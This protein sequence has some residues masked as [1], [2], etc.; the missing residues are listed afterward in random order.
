LFRSIHIAELSEENSGKGGAAKPFFVDTN[1]S[2]YRPM[3]SNGTI[4]PAQLKNDGETGTR[5]VAESETE[6]ASEHVHVV[7]SSLPYIGYWESREHYL[8]EAKNGCSDGDYTKFLECAERIPH[9]KEQTDHLKDLIKKHKQLSASFAEWQKQTKEESRAGE[10]RDADADD[11]RNFDDQAVLNTMS[12]ED[13]TFYMGIGGLQ[14][15]SIESRKE[16]LILR[17][18][19]MAAERRADAAKRRADALEWNLNVSGSKIDVEDCQLNLVQHLMSTSYRARVIQNQV[20]PLTKLIPPEVTTTYR[21]GLSHDINPIEDSEDP[22]ERYLPARVMSSSYHA[23][24]DLCD[25]AKLIDSGIFSE[26]ALQATCENANVST[27]ERVYSPD[28]L[29]QLKRLSDVFNN[30]I[31]KST[32]LSP[33]PHGNQRR[34]VQRYIDGVET[35]LTRFDDVVS[36][37][38]LEQSWFTARNCFPGCVHQENDGVNKILAHMLRSIGAIV[39]TSKSS[40]S[41]RPR[42]RKTMKDLHPFTSGFTAAVLCM[43]GPHHALIRREDAVNIMVRMKAGQGA[44]RGPLD[45]IDEGREQ[46]TSHLADHVERAMDF[47]GGVGVPTFVT[48]VVVGLSHVQILQLHFLEAGTPESRLELHATRLLPLMTKE[49]FQR[50]YK[51]NIL[52]QKFASQWEELTMLLY[53]AKDMPMHRTKTRNSAAVLDN[54]LLA[55][56]EREYVDDQGIL[57][58]WKALL[59]I[60]TASS[61]YL[62]EAF[63]KDNGNLGRMIGGGGYSNVF[64]VSANSVRKVSSRGRNYHIQ[65]EVQ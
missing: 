35:F 16:L 25:K 40:A 42:K 44:Q 48:G 41:M 9:L 47:G 31:E 18:E 50:W 20:Q 19:G 46:L 14:R 56:S 5:N 12:E 54:V 23:V 53:P 57:L 24:R 33:L 1:H 59:A 28:S 26:T 36:M 52:Y 29:D 11:P 4:T 17:W 65:N 38:S 64:Q 37:N 60:M 63:D 61:Q 51:S 13:R 58:G 6:A 45:M 10:G 30:A 8:Q 62:T 2:K 3:T 39:T 49:N 27:S 55:S 21:S 22:E 43:R 15:S 7:A 32:I 34:K